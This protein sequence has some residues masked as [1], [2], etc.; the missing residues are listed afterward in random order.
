MQGWFR[1]NLQGQSLVKRTPKILNEIIFAKFKRVVVRQ[2]VDK[3]LYR[4]PLACI[5]GVYI[6][7]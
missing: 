1:N 2:S 7:T 4:L 3:K 6:Y 5:C